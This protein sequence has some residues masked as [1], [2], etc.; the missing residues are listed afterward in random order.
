MTWWQA[1]KGNS[2]QLR[3]REVITPSLAEAASM[4]PLS[5]VTNHSAKP[6]ER[7]VAKVMKDT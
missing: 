4:S 1:Q 5:H 3:L 7:V 2:A 6:T